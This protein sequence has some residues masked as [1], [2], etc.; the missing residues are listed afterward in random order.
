MTA[1]TSASSLRSLQGELL[2]VESLSNED[3]V[4]DAVSPGPGGEQQGPYYVFLQKFPLE[5]SW[6]M[7][8]H[9]EIIVCPRSTFAGDAAFLETLDGALASIA[10]SR[11]ESPDNGVAATGSE[12]FVE[13][14]REAW[15]RQCVRR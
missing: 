14:E 7:L 2:D 15:S 3:E 12:S 13:I 9:T 11:F 1:R 4:A 8:F 6:R 10:P 5:G